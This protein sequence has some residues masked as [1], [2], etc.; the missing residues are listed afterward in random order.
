MA[1]SRLTHSTAAAPA[2]NDA[3]EAEVDGT[4]VDSTAV[5]HGLTLVHFSAQRKRFLCD[6]G[7]IQELFQGCLA[8]DRGY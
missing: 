5:D 4:A 3:K 1:A 7:C 6:K 8:G 2:E